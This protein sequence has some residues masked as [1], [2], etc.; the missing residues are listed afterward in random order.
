MR[1][2][3]ESNPGLKSRFDKQFQF[4]DY[5]SDDLLEIAVKMLRAEELLAD[6][7]SLAHLRSYF[8][9]LAKHRD[10][11]FGNARSVRKIVEEAVKNQHLRLARMEASERTPEMLRILT[12]ADVE[13]FS[14]ENDKLLSG[15]QTRIGFRSGSE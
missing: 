5:D 8:E 4:K 6:A 9:Y 11:F 10:R 15:N 1:T 12:L 2:F 3:L 7:E 13:E 14:A